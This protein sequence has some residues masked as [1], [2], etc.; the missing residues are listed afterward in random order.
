MMLTMNFHALLFHVSSGVLKQSVASA[1]A[2]GGNIRQSVAPAATKAGEKFNL[3]L[4][5]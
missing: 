2:K 4:V 5:L 3:H 1:A